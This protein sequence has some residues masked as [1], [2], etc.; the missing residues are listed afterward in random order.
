[1]RALIIGG[2]IGG[3]AAGLGL[4]EAGLEVTVFE[5]APEFRAVGAGLTLWANAVKALDTLGV[6]AGLR[7]ESLQSEQG[8][9]HTWKGRTLSEISPRELERLTGA[10]SVAVHRAELIELLASALGR[11]RVRLNC[12][13]LDFLQNDAGVIARFADGSVAN[14]DLLIGADGIRSGSGVR[15][16][17]GTL[18]KY[19]GYVAWQGVL[20]F[21]TARLKIGDYVGR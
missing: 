6:G 8:G 21:D 15:V 13:C 7:E 18:P 16:F 5:R 17:G 2:G 14:G 12:E 11:E 10:P 20:P 1:M 9:I 4:R 3:L 19:A